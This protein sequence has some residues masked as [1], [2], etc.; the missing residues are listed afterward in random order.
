[1]LSKGIRSQSVV[2]GVLGVEL[3]SGHHC[4]SA[5]IGKDA[6]HESR[7]NATR[8]GCALAA[9][10]GVLAW[11]AGF[12]YNRCLSDAG[13]RDGSLA[14]PFP[15]PPTPVSASKAT[16]PLFSPYFSGACRAPSARETSTLSRIRAISGGRLQSQH[17]ALRLGL[18]FPANRELSG[19]FCGF[20]HSRWDLVVNTG[21]ISMRYSRFP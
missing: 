4:Y 7:Q 2:A 13:T 15:P 18:E 3:P 20:C 21:V 1:V 19:Y 9:E 16:F 11:P 6:Y 5:L 10:I 12:R 17:R 8:F 14:V